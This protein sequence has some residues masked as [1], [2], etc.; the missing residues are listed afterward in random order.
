MARS[1]LRNEIKASKDRRAVHRRRM[2]GIY[3]DGGMKRESTP[4]YKRVMRELYG[5]I[6]HPD[7]D[8]AAG[9]TQAE[10]KEMARLHLRLKQR[11][12]QGKFA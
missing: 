8:R 7:F 1:H 5:N 6:H 4:S 12:R 10:H 11:D 3:G 2:E 9:T